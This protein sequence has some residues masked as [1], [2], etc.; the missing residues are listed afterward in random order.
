MPHLDIGRLQIT[1][2]TP[3]ILSGFHGGRQ[4]YSAECTLQDGLKVAGIAGDPGNSDDHVENLFEGEVTTDLLSAPSPVGMT[5]TVNC[6][7]E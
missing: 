4:A 1:R 5:S 3:I 7:T 2:A 6:V